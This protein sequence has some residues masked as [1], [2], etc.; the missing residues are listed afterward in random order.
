MAK[1]FS[2]SSERSDRY[3]ILNLKGDF[4]GSSAFETI[5]YIEDSRKS[6]SCVII[7]TLGVNKIY[8]FG[9][10]A[11]KKN[12]GLQTPQSS[13]LLF[14]GPYAWEFT[15]REDQVIEETKEAQSF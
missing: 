15:D 2:I 4:D 3:L 6:T 1:N 10:G 12:I 14:S 5:D 13:E 7:N 11:F 8:P 9:I